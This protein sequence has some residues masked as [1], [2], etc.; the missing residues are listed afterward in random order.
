MCRGCN[1]EQIYRKRRKLNLKRLHQGD[2]NSCMVLGFEN[3]VV[4]GVSK[5]ESS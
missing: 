2:L 5:P 1:T 4:V 3:A